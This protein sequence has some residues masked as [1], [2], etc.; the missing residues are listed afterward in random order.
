MIS[1]QASRQIG[2]QILN[3]KLQALDRGQKLKNF[4]PN[5]DSV[6]NS[7]LSGKKGDSLLCMAFFK[8]DTMPIRVST[9]LYS[10]NI[11]LCTSW[12]VFQL[13]QGGK[14]YISTTH[15]HMP[16]KY[17]YLYSN[18]H[19]DLFIKAC[20]IHALVRKCFSSSYLFCGHFQN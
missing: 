6:C 5:Q 9:D 12:Y 7:S 18:T 15:I 19:L 2:S 3:Q 14:S 1:K 13:F 4:N 17:I 16:T 8:E 10:F 11:K 20:K